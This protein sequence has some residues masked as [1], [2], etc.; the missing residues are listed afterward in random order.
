MINYKH[1]RCRN[2]KIWLLDFTCRDTY[3]F[4]EFDIL[5]VPI[6]ILDHYLRVFIWK[7]PVNSKRNSFT[8]CERWQLDQILFA[9]GH[10]LSTCCQ[11]IMKHMSKPVS[12]AFSQSRRSN[13]KTAREGYGEILGYSWG[14]VWWGGRRGQTFSG[15]WRGAAAPSRTSGG[16]QVTGRAN[17]ML[18]DYW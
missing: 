12:N 3:T 1:D 17:L 6:C 7:R 14:G 16:G 4:F 2:D 8:S 11:Q 15:G 13:V 5:F 18:I 10:T 9:F